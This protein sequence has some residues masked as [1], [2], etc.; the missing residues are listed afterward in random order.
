MGCQILSITALYASRRALLIDPTGLIK[1]DTLDLSSLVFSPLHPKLDLR[2]QED[3]EVDLEWKYDEGVLKTL[4]VGKV[5]M[6][7][8]LESAIASVY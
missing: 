1:L 6:R 2:T 3:G 7:K 4:D 5:H 8:H